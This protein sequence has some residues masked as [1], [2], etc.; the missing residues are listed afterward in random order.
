MATRELKTDGK[1]LY[2]R[3][4]SIPCG[5][6]VALGSS[7]HLHHLATKKV[8]QLIHRFFVKRRCQILLWK[9]ESITYKLRV[10]DSGDL[11][12]RNESPCE[13][14]KLLVSK[15]ELANI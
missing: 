10:F 12:A 13:F 15:F 2:I 3:P 8:I 14:L 5:S 6:L 1:V 11:K 9:V 4:P 7:Q